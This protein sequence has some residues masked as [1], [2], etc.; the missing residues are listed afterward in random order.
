MQRKK[1]KKKPPNPPHT[2]QIQMSKLVFS[3]TRK[4]IRVC[5]EDSNTVPPV[6]AMVRAASHMAPRPRKTNVVQISE[7]RQ[8]DG[9]RRPMRCLKDQEAA[10]AAGNNQKSTEKQEKADCSRR[11]FKK[12][13]VWGWGGL[14]WSSSG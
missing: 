9:Q 11:P 14:P 13:C 1:P 8:A 4:N 5:S 12:E 2:F 6:I 3:P 7:Q 10:E